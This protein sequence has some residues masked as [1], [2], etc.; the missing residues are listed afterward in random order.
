MQYISKFQGTTF[1]RG[2]PHSSV[3]KETAW[4]AGD[5]GLIPRSGRSTAEWIGYPFQYSW[6]SLVARLVNNPPAIR[7]TWVQ[8]LGC[9][10]P[11]EKGK[12]IHS[13]ILAWRIPWTVKSMGS[14]RVGYDWATFTSL[15]FTFKR[16][17]DFDLN[18][19][20]LNKASVISYLE[21]YINFLFDLPDSTS[22]LLFFST[23]CFFCCYIFGVSFGYVMCG[24]WSLLPDQGSKWYL[25][26]GSAGPKPL[27]C[28]G[29]PYLYPP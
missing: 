7:E 8:S 13:S 1:K 6:A 15:H 22:T 26:H 24:F 2:F 18:L 27:D 19:T 29:S 28:Q 11:L 21:Y 17:P 12:V 9:Q 3:G 16:D 4:N 5:P 25:L 14:Q 23:L 20:I 10:D